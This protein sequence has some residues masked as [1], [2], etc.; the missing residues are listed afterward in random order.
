MKPLSFVY[1]GN[2]VENEEIVYEELC[3]LLS[4]MEQNLLSISQGGNPKVFSIDPDEDAEKIK[5]LVNALLIVIE[6]YEV[7]NAVA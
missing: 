2:T 6:M 7:P 5:Q 4:E 3:S 1:G